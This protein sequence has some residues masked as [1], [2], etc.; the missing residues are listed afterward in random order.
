MFRVYRIGRLI[1]R[2]YLHIFTRTQTNQVNILFMHLLIDLSKNVHIKSGN[3]ITVMAPPPYAAFCIL[4]RS[5][6]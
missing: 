1:P 2:L 4:I 6:I 3:E 5:Y